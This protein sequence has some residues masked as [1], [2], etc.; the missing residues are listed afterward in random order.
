MRI[1]QKSVLQTALFLSVSDFSI[2]NFLPKKA[3]PSMIESIREKHRVALPQSQKLKQEK[4]RRSLSAN[5]LTSSIHLFH[6]YSTQC[7]SI[8]SKFSIPQISPIPAFYSS[9]PAKGHVTV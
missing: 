5:N 3:K 8:T 4:K 2:L 6:V 1:S 7:P 9:K